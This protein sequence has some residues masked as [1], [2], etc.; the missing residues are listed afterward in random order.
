MSWA[1]KESGCLSGHLWQNKFLLAA[2]GLKGVLRYQSCN[3]SKISGL[4]PLPT[5]PGQGDQRL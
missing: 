2:S 1:G 5:F 4:A 3:S